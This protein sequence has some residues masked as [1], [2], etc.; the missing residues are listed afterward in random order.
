MPIALA[1]IPTRIFEVMKAVFD[2]VFENNPLKTLTTDMF[3]VYSKIA[4]EYKIPHQ[5]CIFHSM[6][7]VGDIIYKE[8]KKK[9]KYDAHEK[10]WINS[11][12]TEYRE[13]LRQL[14]YGDAVDKMENFL[15]KLD[16]LPDFFETIGKHLRKHFP[17]LF[18]HLEHDGVLRTS[19]KCETFHSL[20]QIR[21]IKNISKNPWGLLHRLACTIKNYLPNRRTLQNRG[22][23]HIIPTEITIP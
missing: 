3:R 11:L 12:L 18:T 6:L 8:L 19:N 4:K 16:N 7:Y 15:G 9:D 17:N 21:R 5:D 13:I 23:W 2:F 10:I 1:V 14:N 22:D 20:P